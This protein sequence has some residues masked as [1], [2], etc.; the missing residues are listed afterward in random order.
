MLRI[1]GSPHRYVQGPGALRELPAWTARVAGHA[2]V[3]VLT[4]AI[5]WKL[6]RTAVEGAFQSADRSVE[7]V[8]FEGEITR[9]A[10]EQATSM[11]RRHAPGVVVGLG[12]G[13]ALDMGKAVAHALRLPVITAPTIASND[14]PTSQSYAVYDDNHVMAAVERMGRNPDVV[15]V[16]TAMI[17]AAPARFL[18]S[19]IGDA[20]AK[21]FEAEA[22]DIGGARPNGH[23]SPPLRA[24]LMLGE[25]CYGL[26]R[27][28]AADALAAA[29]SG[30]PTPAFEH[31][32]EAC[33]LLSG[34]TFEN[35][36]LSIAH[37]MTRGL[38]AAPS[39]AGCQHGEHVAYGLLVQLHTEG[40]SGEFIR[41]MLAFYGRIGLPRTLRDLGMRA[42]DEQQVQVI[43][44]RSMLAPHL[45]NVPRPVDA[46]MMKDAILRLENAAH[47]GGAARAQGV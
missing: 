22:A 29:G 19:G 36:G 39:T 10:I 5:A 41:D 23:G 28:H 1:F 14:S 17:A 18:R 32:V 38:M 37:S 21:K 11:A 34:L 25:G 12:G 9:A 43:V 3:V 2:Q 40:R 31:V 13:K 30:Q 27:A 47:P 26:I 4:D 20:I 8:L 16:D 35:T 24:G 45:G 46:A 15:L 33:A 7:A 44:E 42:W 6:A